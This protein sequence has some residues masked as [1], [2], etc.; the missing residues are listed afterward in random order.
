MLG[1]ANQNKTISVFE[2]LI[3]INGAIKSIVFIFYFVGLETFSQLV[4][5]DEYGA[6][7]GNSVVQHPN[8]SAVL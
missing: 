6:V 7:S 8:F 3:L 2:I 5:E 4:Y 1:N